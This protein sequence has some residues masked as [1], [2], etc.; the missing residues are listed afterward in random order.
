MTVLQLIA[1]AAAVALALC[2]VMTTA[3]WIRERSGKS[4]FVDSFWTFGVG[5]AATYAALVPF[6]GG[7]SARQVLVAALAAIWSLR[8]G[9]HI[10]DRNRATGDDPRYYQLIAEWGDDAPRRMFW[11]LQSQAAVGVLLALT[12]AVAAHSPPPG[13]RSQDYAG[14][15]IAV[16]ALCGEAL[17]DRQLRTFR[18]DPKNRNAVCDVGLWRW[19]R[20][21]NYF[22]EWLFW[23]AYP[24]IA[25]DGS[26]ENPLEWFTLAAPVVMYWLLVQVSG[27]PPLEQHM[28]RTRGA[29]FH[30]YQRKTSA[31]FPLP[32][33]R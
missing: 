25:F 17:A 20:H 16:A 1:S 32:P 4:G 33:R 18:A 31:F 24:I 3:W 11:F 30:D 19:S 26:G 28:E 15:A 8:L 23:F 10:V 29:A 21:P 5:A 14:V 13:L 7:R 12:I 9:I 27:I 6:S 2:A 22:F